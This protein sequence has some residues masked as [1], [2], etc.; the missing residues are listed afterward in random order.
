[1]SPDV[2]CLATYEGG[3]KLD[4]DYGRTVVDGSTIK[5]G[6]ITA[7]QLV[8]TAALITTSAQ[9]G[10]A[11][12]KAAQ[13][14]NLEVDTIK[15]KDGAVTT[16]IEAEMTGSP[17]SFSDVVTNQV[18][19]MRLVYNA[20]R[21]GRVEICLEW[22][23]YRPHSTTFDS[24][25]HIRWNGDEIGYGQ[26]NKSVGQLANTEII[27]EAKIADGRDGNYSY[28]ATT[29]SLG[30]KYEYVRSYAAKAGQ[31][32]LTMTCNNVGAMKLYAK[33]SMVQK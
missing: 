30:V 23:D 1:M 21:A 2:V 29:T 10:S 17:S 13:I 9:L 28:V 22:L 11:V 8:K 18:E 19:I 24:I 7:T 3:T 20:P 12:V 4:A 31:N 27:T 16:V 5:T 14:G 32:I 26:S 15:I 33:I 25:A 6:T